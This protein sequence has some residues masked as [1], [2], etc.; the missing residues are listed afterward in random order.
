MSDWVE[1]DFEE[2]I[3]SRPTNYLRRDEQPVNVFAAMGVMHPEIEALAKYI[4][5]SEN[6]YNATGKELN[7]FGE[8]A[9]VARDGMSDDDYRVAIFNAVL[10]AAYSGTPPQ[11]MNIAAVSTQSNDVEIVEMQCAAFSVHV[12]GQKV[13]ASIDNLVDNASA[14]G[15]RAYVTF[16]YGMGGFS[17]AG[18]DTQNGVALQAGEDTAIKVGEDTALGILRGTTYLGGSYLDTIF[19][20]GG[21]L[22]VNGEFAGVADDN[23]LLVG[24]SDN[25]NIS[26]T[27]L[28]GAMPR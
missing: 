27:Y 8:Y 18:I 5:D 16:D 3:R 17:L 13:P 20:F 26:E 28:C 14:A 23:Y 22:A 2:A 12:T 15:V 10:S 24:D 6:I 19:N 9:A 25:Y 21:L 11:V 4:Y 7:R 1:F